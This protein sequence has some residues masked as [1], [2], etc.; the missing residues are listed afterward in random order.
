MHILG[1]ST[2]DPDEFRRDCRDGF[3]DC[4]SSE[5]VTVQNTLEAKVEAAHRVC[6]LSH[7]VKH[8]NWFVNREYMYKDILDF[9]SEMLAE[10]PKLLDYSV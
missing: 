1:I 10:K 3:Q 4:V 6:T 2:P 8:R 9:A 7:V 5:D